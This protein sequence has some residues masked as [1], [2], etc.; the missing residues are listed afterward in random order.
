MQLLR[1]NERKKLLNRALELRASGISV[2]PVCGDSSPREP[3]KPAVKWRTYQRQI[4]SEPELRSSF[5]G[6]AQALGIV[7][8]QVSGLVVVDFD[9]H[10]RYQRFCRHLP[11]FAV[12]YTVKTRRG[13]HVYFK[14][15]EK[16]PTHQFAGGDIK[17]ERSYVVAPPS[18]I[19]GFAYS[20]VGA[21]NTIDLDRFGVDRLLNYF[22]VNRSVNVIAGKRVRE[23]RDLDL[24]ALYRRLAPDIGR[25]NALYRAASVGRD[26]GLSREEVERQLSA[27]HANEVGPDGPGFE[28]LSDRMR[29]ARLSIG[30]AFTRGSYGGEYGKSLPN[31]V[32]ETLLKEQGSTVV[33]R[34]LE[35]LWLE[36]WQSEA[37][38]TLA[39]ATE[40]G[41]GHGLNRKSVMQALT[42]EYCSFNGQHIVSRRYVEYLDIKGLNCRRRGRRIELLFQVPS[43][44]RLLSVLNVEGTPS[45]CI[46]R[47]DVRSAHVYRRALHRE[48]IRRLSPQA[49]MKVLS[50]RLGVNA[51]TVRRY[52]VELDV[53]GTA[54]VGRFELT[55][56]RLEV[57]P[58]R[59]RSD[60]RSSTAGYWLEVGEGYRMP[61]WRHIGVALLKSGASPVHVCI[62]RASVWSLLSG[63]VSG[64]RYERISPVEFVRLRL[65][66][67]SGEHGVGVMDRV[68]ELLGRAGRLVS[69]TRYESV[70]LFYDSVPARIAEDKVA[71]TIGGY[72]YAV[73]ERGDQVRRPARRGV[74]YR[75]L[76]EFG[77]GNVFLAVRELYR[78]LLLSMAGHAARGGR[79]EASLD[80]LAPVLA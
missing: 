16:V 67:E 2:I 73:D 37:N 33:A 8:G 23:R 57:L 59:R 70:Q 61:A 6:D 62:R 65:L 10:L 18:V 3:K 1:K 20:Q 9:D 19:G 25:N 49:T 17:G 12:S 38:F 35:I 15:Q 51:R 56:D 63:S 44:S 60:R 40:L 74:A 77:N 11:Q 46:D 66:R 5:S 58:R 72:L 29:E 26:M 55:S 43:L 71:E 75:M 30:S 50:D 54:C 68:R 27:S 22:H 78:D 31:S 53:V 32:R 39:Q 28:S 69:A 64:V 80:W 36:G 14:T 79:T 24:V 34:L 41:C 45:D 76:K 47:F 13:Y 4:A 21:R 7:C 48:Y 42:G 52:N